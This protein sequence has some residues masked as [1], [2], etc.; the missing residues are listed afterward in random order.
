MI[1]PDEQKIFFFG[2]TVVTI[3]DCKAVYFWHSGRVTIVY[4]DV[5]GKKGV[6]Q[7]LPLLVRWA[8][9]SIE[10]VVTDILI[11]PTLDIPVAILISVRLRYLDSAG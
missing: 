9:I 1:S 7:I 6:P 11:E 4:S 10:F 2:T 8:C 5:F 3:K